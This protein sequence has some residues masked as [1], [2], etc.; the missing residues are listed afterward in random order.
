M[1]LCLAGAPD[2]A[3]SGVEGLMK[4]LEAKQDINQ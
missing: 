4:K 3:K 2:G 1:K